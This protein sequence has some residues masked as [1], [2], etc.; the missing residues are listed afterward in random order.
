MPL[1]T[2]EYPQGRSLKSVVVEWTKGHA[3]KAFH[4]KSIAYHQ[5]ALRIGSAFG[6]PGGI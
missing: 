1:N 5:I 2:D 3:M 4:P 6:Q